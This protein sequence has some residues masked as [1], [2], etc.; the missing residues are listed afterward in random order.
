MFC[1]PQNFFGIL[2][3]Y[4]AGQVMCYLKSIG[5]GTSKSVAVLGVQGAERLLLL[6]K[7]PVGFA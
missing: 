4:L 6:S 2:N 1:Y 7:F 5:F 3:F